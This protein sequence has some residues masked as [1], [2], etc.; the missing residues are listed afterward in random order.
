[1]GGETDA[2]DN[3]VSSDPSTL[4]RPQNQRRMMLNPMPVMKIV[5]RH[6]R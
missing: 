3:K 1:M 5:H 2:V 6:W 4:Q